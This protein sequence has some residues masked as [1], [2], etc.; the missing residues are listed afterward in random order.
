MNIIKTC[1]MKPSKNFK[2]RKFKRDK[3]RKERSQTIHFTCDMILYFK[4][5][6]DLP[7]NS[8]IQ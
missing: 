2:K 1:C 3:T 8:Q 5:P 7:E 6:I 4:D